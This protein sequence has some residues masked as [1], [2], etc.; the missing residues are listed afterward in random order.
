MAKKAWQPAISGTI[1]LFRLFWYSWA[2]LAGPWA[3]PIQTT[4][5]SDPRD[6]LALKKWKKAYND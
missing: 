5:K 2:V 6:S 3:A 1:G 4:A